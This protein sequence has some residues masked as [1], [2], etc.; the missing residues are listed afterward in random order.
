MVLLECL[1]FPYIEVL[2]MEP[3]LITLLYLGLS[4]KKCLPAFSVPLRP[5]G[6]LIINSSQNPK[7]MLFIEI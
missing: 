3:I 2:K 1:H 7:K 5:S 4:Q 6:D